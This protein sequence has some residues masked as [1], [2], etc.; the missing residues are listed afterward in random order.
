MTQPFAINKH[1]VNGML[2]PNHV[3]IWNVRGIINLVSLSLNVKLQ[4]III[5][6]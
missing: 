3:V 4:P 5:V 2:K 6:Y 1:I